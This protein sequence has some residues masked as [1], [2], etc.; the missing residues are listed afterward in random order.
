MKANLIG[1]LS[2]GILLIVSFSAT[3]YTVTNIVEQQNRIFFILG[4]TMIAIAG[5]LVGFYTFEFRIRSLRAVIVH[6]EKISTADLRRHLNMDLFR[7]DLRRLAK[8]VENTQKNI[9]QLIT[10]VSNTIDQVSASSKR[11]TDSAEESAQG[12]NQVVAA[13]TQVTSQAEEQV[14]AARAANMTVKEISTK[15]EQVSKNFNAVAILANKTT[16]AVKDGEFAVDQTIKQMENI[17]RTVA[18]SAKMVINLGKRSKEISQIIY[19]ISTIAGQTNL[20]AL[21]AAIEAAHAVTAMRHEINLEMDKHMVTSAKLVAEILELHPNINIAAMRTLANNTG[22]EEVWITDGDGVVTLSN[23]EGGSGFRFPEEGQ[24]GEFRAILT[25]R[26][27]VVTQQPMAR[28]LDGKIFKYVGVGRK[29]QQGF[30]QVGVVFR[31]RDVDN[32]SAG[33]AVVAEEVRKLAVETQKASQHITKL[34]NEIQSETEQ[35]VRAMDDGTQKVTIG[36]KVVL[37]ASESFKEINELV[38]CVSQDIQN[39]TAVMKEAAEG[40]QQIFTLVQSIETAIDI[41]AGQ[42]EA[43]S[44]VTEQQSASAEELA[45][46]SQF[47]GSLSQDLRTTIAKYR[48]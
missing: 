25:N 15:I 33:F 43:V 39:I 27:L 47:L 7:N 21:N 31:K 18:E 14:K 37:A 34:I 23:I 16:E 24:A 20:L 10:Q 29:D 28:N 4:C 11:L 22:L 8:A 3:V 5:S 38:C 9:R 26:N 40:S 1:G 41:T 32:V 13:I 35:A 30:V 19:S 17:K 2:S 45:S 44:A 46:A 6:V 36:S 12:A 42:I 48:L